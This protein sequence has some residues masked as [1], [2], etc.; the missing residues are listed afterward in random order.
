MN[1]GLLTRFN[2]CNITNNSLQ[3]NSR[4]GGILVGSGTTVVVD[5]SNFLNNTGVDGPFLFCK[6]LLTKFGD[7][8]QE[9]TPTSCY[10]FD[11]RFR[12]MS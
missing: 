8:R 4:I 11:E 6:K 1:A 12:N 3:G 2:K 7:Q 9:D 10:V 5:N